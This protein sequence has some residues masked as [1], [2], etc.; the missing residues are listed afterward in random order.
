MEMTL[1]NIDF[2]F[3]VSGW[4]S[5][6]L[7]QPQTNN[8]SLQRAQDE[9]WSQGWQAGPGAWRWLR[10]MPWAGH[11]LLGNTSA[12][13]AFQGI[14]IRSLAAAISSSIGRSMP[15]VVKDRSSKG[16]QLVKVVRDRRGCIQPREQRKAA[17]DLKS[18]SNMQHQRSPV[19]FVPVSKNR[20]PPCSACG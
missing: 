17:L 1:T 2:L 4:S 6:S 9:V 15:G 13:F 7:E 18:S 16:I 10:W 20:N 19:R 11:G 12:P 3:V 14:V 5:L 8:P